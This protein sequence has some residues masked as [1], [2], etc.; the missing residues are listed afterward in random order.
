MSLAQKINDLQPIGPGLPC[1]VGKILADLEGEDKTALEM[2]MD[3]KPMP[4]GVSNRMIFNLLD[5]EG[6]KIAFASVRLHRAKQ[7]RCFIG[8]NSP[9]RKSQQKIENNSS[10]VSGT[11]VNV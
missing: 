10:L 8:K 2:L 6:Y 9:F 4:N 1:G 5:G 3:T 7:C 11:K